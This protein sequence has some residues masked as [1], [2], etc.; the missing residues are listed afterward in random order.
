MTHYL[1]ELYTPTPAW[2]ALSQTA[3]QQFF[4]IYSPGR[5]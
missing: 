3:R 5:G 4:G 1:A 2:L